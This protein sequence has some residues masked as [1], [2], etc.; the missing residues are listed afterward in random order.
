MKDLLQKLCESKQ[1]IFILDAAG[2]FSRYPLQ[3]SGFFITVP[4]IFN[5]I[6]DKDSK[7]DL[8][9]ML[10]S[11]KLYVQTPNP[12]AMRKVVNIA[13]ELG[14]INYLSRADLEVTALYVELLEKGCNV[15]MVTDDYSIQNIV[16]YLGGTFIAIKTKGIK[17]TIKYVNYCPYCGYKGEPEK[18]NKCPVCGSTMKRKAQ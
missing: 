2:I 4:S 14:E 6:K 16:K 18:G 3:F 8:N 11:R 12:K 7:K 1:K 17:R 15:I 9:F 13:K 10:E 5:E